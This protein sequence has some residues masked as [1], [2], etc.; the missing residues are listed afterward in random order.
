LKAFELLKDKVSEERRKKWEDIIRNIDPYKAYQSHLK[1]DPTVETEWT[2]KYSAA[3]MN[4]WNIVNVAGKLFEFLCLTNEISPSNIT[5]KQHKSQGEIFC[6]V[7]SLSSQM[8]A[9]HTLQ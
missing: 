6:C 3:K 7:E 1:N 9:N 4:N 8:C 5:D 2:K